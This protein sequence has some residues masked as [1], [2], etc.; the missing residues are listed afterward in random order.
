MGLRDVKCFGLNN[1]VPELF[2]EEDALRKAE[3]IN[4]QGFESWM[5]LETS[6]RELYWLP[7]V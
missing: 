4:T 2:H 5:Y 6:S 3:V 7:L 1:A